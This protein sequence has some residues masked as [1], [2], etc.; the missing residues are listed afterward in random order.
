MLTRAKTT[1]IFGDTFVTG[2][3]YEDLSTGEK[4]SLTLD[5]IFVTIGAIPNTE[6]VSQLVPLD[7]QGA[8]VADRYGKTSV[9]G[10]FAAGDVTD[11]R[12]A[13]IVVAAGQACSAALS[14]DDYLS[15]NKF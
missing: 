10:F 14:V 8:V 15:R 13:Q 2:L 6:P 1:H 4:K 11:T 12:D 3:E 7:E 9:E 5:G